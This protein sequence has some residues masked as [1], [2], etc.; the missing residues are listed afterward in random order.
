M[1]DYHGTREAFSYALA[2]LAEQDR[3]IV[4]VVPDSLKALRA[5]A[6]A[7]AIPSAGV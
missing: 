1:S 3:R 4:L 6:F 7:R 5:E 2:E